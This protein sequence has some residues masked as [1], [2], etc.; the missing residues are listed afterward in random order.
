MHRT[1]RRVIGIAGIAAIAASLAACAGSSGS[2]PSASAA[3]AG[4]VDLKAAGCPSTIVVQTDWWPESEHGHLYEMF[5]SDAQVET[6]KKAV[7]GTLYSG[8]KSTGVKLEVRAGGAAINYNNV[9]TQMYTDDSITM[10]YVTTDDQ[11]ANSGKV[12]TKAFFAPLD[13]SPI[14]MMWDPTTYPSV[15]GIKDIKSALTKTGGSWLYFSGSAYM[16]YLISAG[17][18]DK[19]Q[20]D[21]SYSGAPD[22]WVAAEGK[23]VQQGFASAEP[24]IYQHEVAAW[25]K[26]V[27]YALLSS[28]GWNPYQSE[29]VVKK[30]DFTK[31]TP[32][33]K[34]LTPVL[35]QAEVD[36][37]KD[38][39]PANA[40]IQKA[41]AGYN[42]GWS[43]STGVAAYSDKTM[44]S[45]KLVQNGTDG[46]IGSFDA[47]RMSDFFTKAKTVYTA[48]GTNIDP[49]LTAS[50]LY[51][52]EFIDPSIGIGK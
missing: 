24:Y 29:M 11:I 50:D 10:G 14:I 20:T 26:P 8:G 36:Y 45:E 17:Y 35:Q 46:A 9:A 12:P 43:Y 19:S 52:N 39:T 21:S 15:T 23:D 44:I 49:S 37:F 41:I 7:I 25:D 4:A 5:G 32:C 30:G 16:Q 51:T 1:L 2:S 38:P 22:K 40:L 42:A 28:V 33:L 3:A 47:K 34:A 48:L 18:I 6:D 13:N 27:K 31:L